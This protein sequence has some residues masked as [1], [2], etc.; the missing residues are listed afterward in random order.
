LRYVA[1]VIVFIIDT[2]ETYSFESQEKLLKQVK[3]HEKPILIYLSKT[4]IA[5]ASTVARLKKKHDAFTDIEALIAAIAK[6]KKD[7]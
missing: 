3:D 6:A 2:T 5:D 7:G 4:D 1:D